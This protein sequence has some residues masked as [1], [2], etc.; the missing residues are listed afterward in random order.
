MD[1][2]DNSIKDGC[3]T[4]GV[5]WLVFLF[6]TRTKVKIVLTYIVLLFVSVIFFDWFNEPQYK[7]FKIT[8]EIGTPTS[9]V[10]Y[11]LSK[12]RFNGWVWIET[13]PTKNEADYYISIHKKW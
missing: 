11:V 6:Q 12:N 5:L 2:S 10:Y 3:W 1:E 13:L 4:S 9:M 8:E 7:E